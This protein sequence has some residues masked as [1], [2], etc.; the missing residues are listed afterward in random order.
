MTKD[1]ARVAA[2]KKAWAKMSPAKKAAVKARLKRVRPNKGGGGK[3]AAKPKPKG[4]PGGGGGSTALTNSKRK[5][6]G[7][8][9]YQAVKVTGEAV[10]PIT[11]YAL[12]KTTHSAE[13]LIAHVQARTTKDLGFGYGVAA[14]DF[15]ASKH[16]FVGH[17]GALSRLSVTAILPEAYNALKAFDDVR[18]GVSARKVHAR[19][20]R[21][22][23]GYNPEGRT[24]EPGNVEFRTYHKAKW[25]GALARFIANRTRFGRKLTAPIRENVLKELGGAV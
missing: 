6:R 11:D 25:L 14:V 2:G 21:R 18:S 1:P 7:G 24:F 20:A 10:M 5:P 8:A 3:A 4:N 9:T 22:M 23:T 12:K 17:A 19:M 16:R 15:V 13:G